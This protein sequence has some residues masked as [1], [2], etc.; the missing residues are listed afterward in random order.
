MSVGRGMDPH[1]RQRPWRASIGTRRCA[2][3]AGTTADG[4]HASRIPSSGEVYAQ[5]T[6]LGVRARPGG[7]RRPGAR[8]EY[9]PAR[10]GAGRPPPSRTF[11]PP[12]RRRGNAGRAVAQLPRGW[13]AIRAG[14]AGFP[15]LQAGWGGIGPGAAGFPQPPRGWVGILPGAAALG[16]HSRAGS[17]GVAA[18]V[19][20]RHQEHRKAITR[21][22]RRYGVGGRRPPRGQS[23]ASLVRRTDAALAAISAALR[24]RHIAYMGNLMPRCGS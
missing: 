19:E 14:A 3:M 22:L 18:G 4:E 17:S 16:R 20:A 10:A 6:P 7:L 5:R 15:Q 13:K 2:D 8:V 24:T 21:P 1:R 12:A 23:S 9:H 11:R